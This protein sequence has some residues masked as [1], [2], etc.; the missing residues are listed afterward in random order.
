MIL[1]KAVKYKLKPNASQKADLFRM[2]NADRFVYNKLLGLIKDFY[3]GE[4]KKDSSKPSIPSG[5]DLIKEITKLKGK[6]QWLYNTPND[7]LQ[8]SASNLSR[9]FDG[10]YRKGGYP[11]FKS[12]KLNKQ[13]LNMYAGSRSK[14]KDNEL[15]IPNRKEPIKFYKHFE[16]PES[17]KITGYTISKDSVGDYWLSVTYKFEVQ[18]KDF[19]ISNPLGCDL[20]L[21]ETLISSDSSFYQRAYTTK[22]FEKKLTK[23]QKN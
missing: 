17:S 9:A 8:A 5:M 22:V 7:Y 18:D 3:F 10:F 23:L 4:Y 19:I 2:F 15:F 13:S 12:R 1:V 16:L 6:Y 21:K 14:I 11:K 20:G